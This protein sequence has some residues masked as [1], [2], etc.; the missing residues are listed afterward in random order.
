MGQY[1]DRASTVDGKKGN[2]S[3]QQY[4]AEKKAKSEKKKP[5]W[6]FMLNS[7]PGAMVSLLNIWTRDGRVWKV[8]RPQASAKYNSEQLLKGGMLGYYWKT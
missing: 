8:G 3:M 5:Q 6:K 4:R 2:I 7:T 1:L